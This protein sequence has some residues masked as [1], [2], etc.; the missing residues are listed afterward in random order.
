MTPGEWLNGLYLMLQ[1]DSRA[2]S[3]LG[4]GQA[5]FYVSQLS[6]SAVRVPRYDPRTPAAYLTERLL[7]LDHVALLACD[8]TR[9]LAA[10]LRNSHPAGA[11]WDQLRLLIEG[12]LVPSPMAAARTE[13]D[14]LIVAAIGSDDPR[15]TARLLR[16][17]YGF[18]RS[19]RW[20]A[21]V[22]FLAVVAEVYWWR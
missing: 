4:R 18:R 19:R 16:R 8:L 20:V 12:E 9:L 7:A 6:R 21:A 22:G 14:P 5:L 17:L 15:T 2:K 3:A 10:A 11:V 13:C 1:A